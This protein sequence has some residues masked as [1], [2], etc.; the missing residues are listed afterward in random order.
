MSRLRLPARIAR[1]DGLRQ[2]FPL[3]QVGRDEQRFRQRV[4]AADVGVEQVGPRDGLSAQ[5]GVEVEAT[6]REAAAPQ[7]LVDGERQLV[8]RVRELVGVPAVLVIAAVGIDAAEHPVAHRVGDLVMEAVAGERRVVGLEVE[9]VLTLQAMSDEESV[10]SRGVA[11]VLVA[12]VFV[13]CLVP[14]RRAA[15]IDPLEALR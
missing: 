15:K 1:G 4:D 8:D 14:A 6:G 3:K 11:V 5:L 10:D 2:G 9:L 7:D 12:V 13:A